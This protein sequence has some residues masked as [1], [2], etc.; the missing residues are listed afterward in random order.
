MLISQDSTQ[1]VVE[2]SCF[3]KEC[4]ANAGEAETCTVNH[5]ECHPLQMDRHV[6]TPFMPRFMAERVVP[7]DMRNDDSDFF[8]EWRMPRMRMPRMRMP[9]MRMQWG[10]EFIGAHKIQVHNSRKK[11]KSHA[12]KV[13]AGPAAHLSKKKLAKLKAYRK[14][15]ASARKK[16]MKTVAKARKGLGN[17]VKSHIAKAPPK[18]APFRI[19]IVPRAATARPEANNACYEKQCVSQGGP[20]QCK[21]I[22]LRCGG[23]SG[24]QPFS[25]WP[26]C[27]T[28]CLAVVVAEV[29]ARGGSEHVAQ[30][31]M[32]CGLN[33]WAS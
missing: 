11:K 28:E 15:I 9:R 8:D 7:R 24:S 27:C 19:R 5:H 25:T 12:L 21:L 33:L 14:K 3:G 32:S 31:C 16:F 26:A 2:R 23:A 18:R 6:R 1:A 13:V 22:K 4:V 20:L 17:I 30:Q 10:P 29:W